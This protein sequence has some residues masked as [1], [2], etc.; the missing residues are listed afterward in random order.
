M[1]IEVREVAPLEEGIVRK[2]DAGH[3]IQ[4]AKGDLLGLGEE[5]VDAAIEDE[6]PNALDG[7]L[8]LR[9]NFGGIEHIEIEVRRELLVEELQAEFPLGVG[10]HLDGVPQIAAVKIR[11]GTVNLHCFVPDHRLQPELRFPM[12]LDKGRL[13]RH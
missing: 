6:S 11:I 4:R 8:L 7:D 2:V 1:G 5:I 10:A 9:D 13:P 3:D 12:E